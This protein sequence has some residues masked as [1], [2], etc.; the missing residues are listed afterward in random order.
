VAASP[1]TVCQRRLPFSIWT[2]RSTLAHVAA[3]CAGA[4]QW[5]SS[6]MRFGASWLAFLVAK[7]PIGTASEVMLK[8]VR[9]IMSS[10]VDLR[11]EPARAKGTAGIVHLQPRHRRGRR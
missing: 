7:R 10:A 1:S 5:M 3:G 8:L 9:A 6:S 4:S 11:Q 2:Q